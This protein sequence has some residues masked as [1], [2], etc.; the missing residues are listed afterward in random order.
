MAQTAFLN[1]ILKFCTTN[2]IFDFV[3]INN[4]DD[5]TD[6][7]PEKSFSFSSGLQ[8]KKFSNFANLKHSVVIIIFTIFV[9]CECKSIMRLLYFYF[10]R[11]YKLNN[12]Q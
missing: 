1:A 9:G 11:F 5:P 8:G 2:K 7:L 12:L 10:L 3:F 6:W 4:Q